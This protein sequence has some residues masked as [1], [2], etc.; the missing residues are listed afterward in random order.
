MITQFPCAIL[1]KTDQSPVYVA[2]AE[3]A[4]II[5]A[6]GVCLDYPITVVCSGLIL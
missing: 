1:E 2:E 4:E 5:G 6:D 3:E